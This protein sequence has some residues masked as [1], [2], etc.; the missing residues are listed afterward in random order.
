MRIAAVSLILTG[1]IGPMYLDRSSPMQIKDGWTVTAYDAGAD[2]A[3]MS[4]PASSQMIA[5]DWP[6]Y[7]TSRASNA[8]AAPTDCW[9][10]NAPTVCDDNAYTANGTPTTG[11]NTPFCDRDGACLQAV[12]FDGSDDWY[13]GDDAAEWQCAATDCTICALVAAGEA[14]GDASGFIASSR[15]EDDGVGDYAGWILLNQIANLR[16]QGAANQ[17]GG[18]GTVNSVAGDNTAKLPFG[19]TL[20][21]LSIDV[22][23]NQVLSANGEE[24]DSDAAGGVNISSSKAVRI[25]N[26]QNLP[27]MAQNR[28]FTG[29]ISRVWRWGSALSSVQAAAI[30][31]YLG[32]LDARNSGTPY[33]YVAGATITGGAAHCWDGSTWQ[34]FYDELVPVG[35]EMPAGLTGAGLQDSQGVLPF[36]SRTNKITYADDLSSWT[37]IGTPGVTDEGANGVYADKRPTY[38]I[39]DN[40]AAALEGV[41]LTTDIAALNTGSKIQICATAKAD[42]GTETLDL[43]V[44]EQTGAGCSAS[45]IEFTAI[46]LTTALKRACWTHTVAD[47]DCTEID[48]ELYAADAADVAN[49]G[50]KIHLAA[51]DQFNGTGTDSYPWIHIHTAGAAVANG[52]ATLNWSS[53]DGDIFSDN[54]GV[55]EDGTVI[56]IDYTPMH[57]NVADTVVLWWAEDTATANDYVNLLRV[58]NESIYVQAKSTASGAVNIFASTAAYTWTPGTT[59]RIRVCIA[60]A[61]G[62]TM[63]SVNGVSIAGSTNNIGSSPDSLDKIQ[64]GEFDQNYQAGGVVGRLKMTEP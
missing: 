18:A 58:A 12:Y 54:S 23:G 4:S 8:V 49:T 55:M 32:H 60:L 57:S 5:S 33:Y 29:L 39:Q 24:L 11:I 21:C 52:T 47:G 43:K 19:W 9:T 45:T 48:V 37:A 10:G 13:D 35:C 7:L 26:V 28:R 50:G 22:D 14:T 34:M 17:N 20:L 25:G 46:T 59:Y 56:L 2:F 15:D 53:A 31:D 41:Y 61:S 38:S 42:S 6:A 1:V 44:N 51:A 64:I 36:A 40:S 16:F 3:Q 62:T 30:T 63:V 27:S